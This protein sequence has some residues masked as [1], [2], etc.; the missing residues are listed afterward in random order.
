MEAC[1]NLY[2]QG[3]QSLD[4]HIEVVLGKGKK[5]NQV[6]FYYFVGSLAIYSSV[7]DEMD[8]RLPEENFSRLLN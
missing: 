4:F 1:Q 2:H 8:L 7:L 5:S 3:Q 6:F